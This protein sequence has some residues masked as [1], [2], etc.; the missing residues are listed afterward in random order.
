MSP[1]DNVTDQQIHDE[2][3]D[4]NMEPLVVLE[5]VYTG[6]GDYDLMEIESSV[7]DDELYAL[8]FPPPETHFNEISE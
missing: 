7:P 4:R 1:F 2:I 5:M 3:A 8:P 6:H